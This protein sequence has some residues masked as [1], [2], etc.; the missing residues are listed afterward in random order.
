MPQP[1]PPLSVTA[2]TATTALGAGRGALY[3]AL[4][5]SR[6]GLRPNDFGEPSDA[7]LPTWIGRVEAL[8]TEPLPPRLRRWDCRN[9]RLAWAGLQA[10]GFMNA[11]AAARERYGA[12][13]VAVVMGTSTSS[14]VDTE[15]A[16]TQLDAQGRVPERI[17]DGEVHTTH[18]LGRFVQVALDLE[19]PSETVSTACSSSAKVFACAERMIRLGLV[20]AAVVGGADSLCASVLFGFNALELL[21][22][23]PCQPFDAARRGISVGE[24][25]GFALLER[26]EGRLAPRLLGYGETSDAHHMSTPHPLG[27]GAEHALDDALARSGLNGEDIDYINLHGT[28]TVL[29]DQV[30]GA[31]V[32]RRFPARTHA[33]STKGVTGH[34]L[35]AAGIVEAVVSL[36]ALDTGLMPGTVNSLQLD[37]ICGPQVRLRSARGHVRHVLSN[38]FGF[39]GNNCALIFGE[40]LCA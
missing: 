7:R 8:D 3:A 33:S 34:T 15:W 35:G 25:S 21:S 14:V 29:N 10:D 36:L 18:S 23:R 5:E 16:Y 39:G 19:G 30:E 4:Q 1:I 40:G 22:G 32:A 9:N 26:P 13:R 12:D 37:P 28:G 17:R 2:Y 20:D 38:S 11:V 27:A 6:S 31:L 24:A